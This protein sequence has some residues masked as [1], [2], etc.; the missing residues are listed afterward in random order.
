MNA[1][2]IRELNAE[3]LTEALADAKEELFNLRFQLA[4][5]QLD[6]TSRFQEVKKEIARIRTIMRERTAAEENE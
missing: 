1:A 6:N 4:T 3:E 2:E 5:N